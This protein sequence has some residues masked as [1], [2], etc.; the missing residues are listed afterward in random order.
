LSTKIR[1]SEVTS[2]LPKLRN[3]AITDIL[4]EDFSKVMRL[5]F[6]IFSEPVP[7][8]P[9]AVRYTGAPY[10]HS[11]EEC[12]SLQVFSHAKGTTFCPLNVIA[13]LDK[14]EIPHSAYIE[15][16]AGQGKLIR[17]RPQN[18]KTDNEGR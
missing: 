13:I 7:G 10:N 3:D 1:V 8:K 12:K 4:V 5:N 18:T 14:F 6:A 2:Q 15:A 16:I 17:M 9:A 11:D